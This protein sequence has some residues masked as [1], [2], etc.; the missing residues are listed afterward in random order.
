MFQA[1]APA[2]SNPALNSPEPIPQI[3]RVALQ[4]HEE[5]VLEIV[6]AGGVTALNPLATLLLAKLGVHDQVECFATRAPS[7]E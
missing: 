2:D 5:A 1:V 6:R 7:H 3:S 4:R